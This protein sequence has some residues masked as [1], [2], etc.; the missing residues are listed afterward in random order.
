MSTLIPSTAD[1]N[2]STVNEY[3]ADI[4]LN[5]VSYSWT[6]DEKGNIVI[7]KGKGRIMNIFWTM[8][9]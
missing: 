2:I 6:I 8:W 3:L 5:R 9:I 4:Y 7:K 1:W